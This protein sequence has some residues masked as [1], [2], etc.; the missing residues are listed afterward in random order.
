MGDWIALLVSFFE[1]CFN[2][3]LFNMN[4][5]SGNTV[6]SFG[7]ILIVGTIVSFAVSVFWKGAKK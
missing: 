5:S 4:I 1:S 2:N 7:A 3:I 6:A